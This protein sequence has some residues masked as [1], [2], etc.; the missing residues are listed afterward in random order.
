[1]KLKE[2]IHIDD[3][4]FYLVFDDGLHGEVDLKG[5]ISQYVSPDETDT[6]FLNREW[7]CLEFKDHTVDIEPKTLYKYFIKNREIE[8]KIAS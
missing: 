4:I 8:G 2:F 6:A 5:L 1:M 7:G 3:Y